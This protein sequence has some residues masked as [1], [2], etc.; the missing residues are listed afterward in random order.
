MNTFE[1]EGPERAAV[2]ASL[3]TTK[4]KVMFDAIIAKPRLAAQSPDDMEY[5][6]DVHERDAETFIKHCRKYA[7]RKNIKIEDISHIIKSF[8]V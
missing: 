5:W 3:L 6:V 1:V 7:L 4:G 2:Y 8:T